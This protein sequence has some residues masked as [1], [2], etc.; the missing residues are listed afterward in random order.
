MSPGATQHRE[1][2]VAGKLVLS[3]GELVLRSIPIGTSR[4]T[5]GRRPHN[6]IALDDLT[7]SGEHAAILFEAGEHVIR[8]LNSR[9][10]TL[11]NGSSVFARRLEHQDSIEIGIYRLRYVLDPR[12]DAHPG[13][14]AGPDGS[15]ATMEML[16]GPDRG[17]ERVCDRPILS[18]TGAGE[19]V[20]V[21]SHRKSGWVITHL[22]GF[23]TPLV[24][25]EPIGLLSH[26]LVDGDLIELAGSLFRF[27][28][29]DERPR[30]TI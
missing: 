15:Y 5:I 18:I 19:Q 6:D 7:V 14:A 25:G 23:A 12:G 13:R 10:G 29:Y 2:T 26:L 11:V 16:T 3:F 17:S 27:H 28:E 30:G 4:I 1:R 8:D 9:N 22:E 21:L 20:A 24:N